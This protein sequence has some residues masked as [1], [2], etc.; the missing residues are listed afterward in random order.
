[1]SQVRVHTWSDDIQRAYLVAQ[2]VRQRPT[3]DRAGVQDWNKVE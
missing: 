3:E 1:M 2:D